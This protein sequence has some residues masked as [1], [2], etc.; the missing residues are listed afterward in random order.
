MTRFDVTLL[1]RMRHDACIYDT[2]HSY[3][4]TFICHIIYHSYVT[5][6]LYMCNLCLVFSCFVCSTFVSVCVR[7]CVCACV[8]V[9]V[10]MCLYV[11]VCACVCVCVRVRVYVCV[12]V[13]VRVCACTTVASFAAQV[14]AAKVGH[15]RKVLFTLQHVAECS[16]MLQYVAAYRSVLQ[17]V[18]VCCSMLQCAPSRTSRGRACW[19]Q[20]QGLTCDT[21]QIPQC[22]AHIVTHDKINHLDI[23]ICGAII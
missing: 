17:R 10:C 23:R 15:K 5:Q 9:C 4:T 13:C 18:A 19:P 16:S 3:V 7:L 2:T 14:A 8:C 12:C 21:S 6:P 11:Y 22:M 20:R 1:I